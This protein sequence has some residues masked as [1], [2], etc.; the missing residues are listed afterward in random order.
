MGSLLAKWLECR[1][2]GWALESMEDRGQQRI[3]FV[4]QQPTG[5]S[6]RFFL[7]YNAVCDYPSWWGDAESKAD[8]LKRRGMTEKQLLVGIYTPKS[9]MRLFHHVPASRVPMCIEDRIS[10]PC[11]PKEVIR[12]TE[13]I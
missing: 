10:P 2:L 9:R 7:S 6:E 8:L 5:E 1:D 4:A 13:D 11:T 12:E 3:G